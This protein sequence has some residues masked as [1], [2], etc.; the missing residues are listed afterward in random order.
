MPENKATPP[1]ASQPP[2]KPIDYAH[3]PMGE[4]FSS[5]KWTLPPIGIVAIAIVAVA[6]VV[7]AVVWFTRAKPGAMGTIDDI[8]AVETAPG[9]V[10]VAVQVTLHNVTDKPF[11]VRQVD[12]KLQASDGKEY[13]DTAASGADF[14]RYFQ[15]FPEL[16][17]H[18]TAEPLK[19]DIRIPAGA[20]IRGAAI[21]T[22]PV[23]KEAFGQRKSFSLIVDP[24]DQPVPVVLTK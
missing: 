24:F 16:R 10:M 14:E 17:Q 2:E 6:I 23:A 3:V 8:A 21:F 5:S 18:A 20:T 1:S 19:R 12:A 22:F 15:A 4:E 13:Q 11:W 7:T 9:N